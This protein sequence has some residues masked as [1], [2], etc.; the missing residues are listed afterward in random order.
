MSEQTAHGVAERACFE[1]VRKVVGGIE[2]ESCFL[3]DIL[4]L[5]YGVWCFQVSGGP[6]QD[7]NFQTTR[8]GAWY[9]HGHFTSQS[10]TRQGALA[11]IDRLITSFPARKQDGT[12]GAAPN[13]RLFEVTEYPRIETES[14]EGDSGS[15]MVFVVNADFRVVFTR[16]T[17][18]G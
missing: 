12:P 2:N 13:V 1:Y 4:P 10:A 11:V 18:G 3:G 16:L 17:T 8:P 7:Q 5:K 15:V 9:A 14:V 6:T